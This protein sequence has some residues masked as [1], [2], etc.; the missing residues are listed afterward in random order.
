MKRLPAVLLGLALSLALPI[1]AHAQ[2]SSGVATEAP[3]KSESAAAEAPAAARTQSVFSSDG[4]RL[5]LNLSRAIE[6]ALESNE[7]IMISRIDFDRSVAD[8]TESLGRFDPVL[9]VSTDYSDSTTPQPNLFNPT[10][11]IVDEKAFNLNFSL[12]GTLSPGTR[13]SV[14]LTNSRTESTSGFVLLSPQYE[15][16]VNAKITQPL[17]Q[18]FG[19]GVNMGNVTIARTQR[20]ISAQ[21]FHLEISERVLE[22]IDAYWELAYALKNLKNQRDSLKVAE[23]LVRIAENRVRVKLDPPIALTQAREGAARR[24]ERVVIAENQAGLAEDNLKRILGLTKNNEQ[25]N[26]RIELLER[27]EQDITLP[28]AD[29]AIQLARRRRPDYEVARLTYENLD[30]AS[31]MAR[32]AKLPQLD[33]SLEGGLVGLSGDVA[34]Q[35]NSINAIPL[36][37]QFGGEFGRTYEQ[38]FDADTPY[39][40]VSATFSIALGSREAQAKLRKAILDQQ[41]ALEE[42]KIHDTRILM[43]VRRAMREVLTNAKRIRTTELGRELAEENLA[44][45]KRRYEVGL[46]TSFDVLEQE[47]NANTARSAY[48]RAIADYNSSIAT[49]RHAVGTLLET[50]D[51]ILADEPEPVPPPFFAR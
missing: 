3:A 50:Y 26:A 23:D 21:E 28:S 16:A 38:I 14:N 1:A 35:S 19:L 18:G 48:E 22:V 31:R 51:I 39:W 25:L 11:P 20:K 24:E 8:V 44:A 27:G 9:S 46:S 36:N 2:L 47:E 40:K 6:L 33:L 17:L 5:P 10:S 45:E 13:Y 34:P 43:E 12:G 49:Y 4:A 15:T 7:E 30:I 42:F 29:E 32:N 37:Q 41:L